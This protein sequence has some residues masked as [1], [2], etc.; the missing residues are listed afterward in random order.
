M[1]RQATSHEHSSGRFIALEGGEG[2]GKSTQAQ[3]LADHLGARLTREPGGTPA[4]ERLRDIVLDPATGEL[5]FRAEVLLIAAAR[6]DHV[7]RVIRPALEGGEDVVTD[8][9]VASSLAYQGH[10]RRLGVE[11]V[12]RINE[13]ATGGLKPDLTI[14]LDVPEDVAAQRMDTDLD[15]LEAVGDGFHER[16]ADGYRALAAADPDAWAVVDGAGS[17]DEV[18]AR[19][20]SAVEERLS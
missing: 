16:V 2:C 11:D 20:L 15:R 10:G 14:L 12:A 13:W 6:A 19:V 7:A 5:D 4:G 9:Y 3:R 8:R 1:S 17:V 18:F